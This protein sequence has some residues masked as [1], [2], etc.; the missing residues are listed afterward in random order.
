MRILILHRIPYQK[1][2]YHRAVDHDLHEVTYFGKREALDTLPA[3]LRCATS[4]RPG[5]ASAFEEARS[6]LTREPKRFDRIISLSEY[7]LL[8][9]A[10][11]REWLRVPGP[12]VEQVR[13]A[14][15]KTLMK[16]VVLRAGLSA[17]RF[18]SLLDFLSSP[19]SATWQGATV[20]KPHSGASSEE[21]VVFP[22]VAEAYAAITANRSRV[23]GLDTGQ[24]DPAQYEIEEFVKGPVLHFDGLMQNGHMLTMTAS[25]YVGDC[26]RF[27]NGE[28]LGSFHV[29]FD[30]D[31]RAWVSTALNA[32]GI[33][34]GSFHLEAIRCHGQLVFL[35]VANR[36]GG[37][38]VV[39]T[40]ELA[41]GIHLPSQEL[42]IL[43]GEHSGLRSCE[44]PRARW[45]G[46]FVY[47][48]HH[49]NHSANCGVVGADA[50]RRSPCVVHWHELAVGAPLPRHITYQAHE[51]PLAG[52]VATGS[53]DCTR[54]W[55]ERLFAS[56][57]QRTLPLQRASAEVR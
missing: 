3:S 26:L 36:V 54:A 28:P 56:V 48:G 24:R 25:E 5:A 27:A 37:A 8:D 49:L 55:I 42:R 18:L 13:L 47:P 2:E 22:S 17:P 21:V 15:D 12:A 45:H 29:P 41:T 14:R 44:Q 32:T 19:R 9:A 6:W 40:F 43:L 46:W 33:R 10:R 23:P 11:L 16:T 53:A 7:E 35:E 20:L 50:V 52:V 38:D 39:R 57:S 4:E 31:V 51:T 30:D 1:I 34:D